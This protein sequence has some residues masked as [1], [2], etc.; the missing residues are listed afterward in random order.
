FLVVCALGAILSLPA[1]W[2]QPSDDA[3]PADADSVIDVNPDDQRIKARIASIY[4]VLEPL[5]GVEVDVREGVVLLSGAVSNQA[6]AER[7]LALASQIPGVITV[8]DAIER[9]RDVQGNL[10]P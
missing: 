4:Q 5:V 7:A 1:V 8:D 3:M 10:S 9:R 6:Q 2:A